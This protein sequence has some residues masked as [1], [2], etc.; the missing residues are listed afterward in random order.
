MNRKCTVPSNTH[1][2]YR[3]GIRFLPHWCTP[4]FSS[5]Y[6]QGRAILVGW[7]DGI[8]SPP[9]V[10][11]AHHPI[12]ARIPEVLDLVPPSHLVIP[13]VNKLTFF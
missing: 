5:V 4:Q 10:G 6:S 11:L 9:V 3:L 1:W 8:H 7:G 13:P 12:K 2:V